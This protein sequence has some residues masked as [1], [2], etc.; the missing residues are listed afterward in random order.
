MKL[1][2]LIGMFIVM[3]LVLMAT[4][5]ISHNNTYAADASY[6]LG[7]TNV[8][9]KI[10]GGAYGIGGLKGD[11][12]PTKKVWKIVSYPKIG[13]YTI[14]YANAFYCL[15]AEY[16]FML[17]EGNAD[18]TRVQ[19]NYNLRY[20]MK[21]EKATVLARLQAIDVFKNDPNA[22]NKVM[23]IIDN[24][25]LPKQSSQDRKAMLLI[26]AGIIDRESELQYARITDDDIEVVQQLAIWY[27]TNPNNANYN[28]EQLPTLL[29]NN[30]SNSDSGYNDFTALYPDANRGRFR[31]EECDML[32]QY[33]L[34][35]AKGQGNYVSK[36][37]TSPLTFDKTRVQVK[38]ETGGYL[39][40]TIPN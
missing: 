38:E 26:N 22:Y 40:R 13:D 7:L 11:G 1:K 30:N 8:R 35:G 18:V 27:F 34:N 36:D 29:F 9:A 3:L 32:Y 5:T 14:S 31:Q 39:V 15:K 4:L 33:L 25:Y 2:K 24:M 6:V 19:K 17:Q 16:G 21:S 10:N 20:D 23:W 12:T 28:N 37:A